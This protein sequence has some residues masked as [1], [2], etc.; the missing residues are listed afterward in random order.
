MESDFDAALKELMKFDFVREV[1]SAT[2]IAA[3]LARAEAERRMLQTLDFTAPG[4]EGPL[5]TPA[6]A[7]A[8]PAPAVPA[9]AP[10]PAAAAAVPPAAPKVVQPAAAPAAADVGALQAKREADLLQ[11]LI[12]V[13]QP[14]IE[15]ELRAKLHTQLAQEIRLS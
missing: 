10:K 7:A 2:A 3:S 5:A 8:K 4:D 6:P 13:L 12:A 14:R 9:V 11:K 15:E 1:D